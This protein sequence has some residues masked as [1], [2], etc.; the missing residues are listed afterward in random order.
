MA[1]EGSVVK[2]VCP[3]RVKKIPT[4]LDDKQ[5]PYVHLFSILNDPV[6]KIRGNDRID[7]YY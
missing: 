4:R 6:L 5:L 2:R 7:V 3:T 1:E